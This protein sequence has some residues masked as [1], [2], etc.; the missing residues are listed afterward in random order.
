MGRATF[1]EDV[2]RRSLQLD[3][4]LRGRDGQALAGPDVEG[5]AAPAPRIDV[6]PQSRER[7]GSR[8]RRPPPAPCD[9]RWYWPRTTSSGRNGR[10]ESS[11]LY[12]SLRTASGVCPDGASMARMLTD[13]EDVVL[14]H[15][16]DG[17]GGVVEG[18]AVGHVEGLGHGDLHATR[19]GRVPD[20]LEESS[21]RNGSRAGSGPLPCPGSGRCGR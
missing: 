2:E 5:H 7:L 17:A 15:V 13:L 21:W 14:D 16:A 3:E 18:A 19:R 4:D 1:A 10:I 8:S 9:S 6:Q 12:C 11:T 20:G